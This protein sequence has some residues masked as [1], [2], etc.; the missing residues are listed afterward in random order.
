MIQ[1]IRLLSMNTS[2]LL[3]TKFHITDQSFYR[4]LIT[5][6]KFIDQIQFL[7]V[8]WRPAVCTLCYWEYQVA[9]MNYQCEMYTLRPQD[10][11]PYLNI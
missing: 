10:G 11:R 2:F 3:A 9:F 8:F 6:S 4:S 5:V 7:I 1:T